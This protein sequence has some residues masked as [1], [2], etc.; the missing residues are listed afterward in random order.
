MRSSLYND[1]A[2]GSVSKVDSLGL[3]ESSALPGRQALVDHYSGQRVL[4]QLGREAD[5]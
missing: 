4:A 1:L 2:S 3:V 5:R